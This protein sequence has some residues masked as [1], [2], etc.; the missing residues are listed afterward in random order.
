MT[1][2]DERAGGDGSHRGGPRSIVVGSDLTQDSL[3]AIQAGIVLARG[4]GADLHLVHVA[5]GGRQEGNVDPES[6]LREQ[7]Q[8]LVP[9]EQRIHL[10]VV[11]GVPF[12]GLAEAAAR[13]EADLVVLGAHRPRRVL[14]GLLGTTAD[15]IIRTLP[16]PAL[17]VNRSLSRLPRR[18]ILATDFSPAADRA[19]E[20]VER[21]LPGWIDRTGEVEG[22]LGLPL[23]EVVNISAFAHPA[24]RPHP[25]VEPLRTRA[26]RLEESTGL[27]VRPRSLSAPLAP[28]GI[29]RAAEEARADLIVLGTHGHGFLARALLG[30]VASE[31]VRTV[32]FP[33]LLVP[34]A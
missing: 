33:I 31:V 12:R 4:G 25:Q 6:L 24:Y 11:E 8:H 21:W 10:H 13:L 20:V 26:G 7:A 34:P 19:L 3:P 28:E 27:P 32:P 17:A 2:H 22:E 1:E 16:I 18:I 29:L 9:P 30:G 14:D 15:R 5:E 23:V